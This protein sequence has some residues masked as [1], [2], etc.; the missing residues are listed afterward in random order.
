MRASESVKA[1]DMLVR[2][3]PRDL[4]ARL[5]VMS[6]CALFNGL[7]QQEC[8]ALAS[9]ATSHTFAPGKSL[10]LQGQQVSDVILI[11]RGAIKLTQCNPKGRSIIL[12]MCTRGDTPIIPL[13][14]SESRHTCAAHAVG[15]CSVMRWEDHLIQRAMANF[16][17]IRRNVNLLASQRLRELEDRVWELLTEGGARRLARAIIRLTETIGREEPEGIFIPIRRD[18]LAKMSGITMFTVSRYIAAWSETGCILG[19]RKEALVVCNAR[20]L[21]ASCGEA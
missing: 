7:T 18:D 17:E 12:R 19:G 13:E 10:F 3:F 5:A 14:G 9:S 4:S 15:W 8:S 1:S 11:D 20:E 16:P 21:L 2:R 6:E